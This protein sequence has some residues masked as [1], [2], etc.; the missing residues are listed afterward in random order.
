MRNYIIWMGKN[1]DYN[2]IIYINSRT[3]LKSI[4]LNEKQTTKQRTKGLVNEMIYEFKN[5]N[6]SLTTRR[7]DMTMLRIWAMM[8][9]SSDVGMKQT[10]SNVK[11]SLKSY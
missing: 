9:I 10:K 4:K 1:M 8:N 5:S 3:K 7:A 11:H 6:N 2:I